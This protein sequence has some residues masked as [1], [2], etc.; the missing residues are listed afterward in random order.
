MKSTKRLT[1]FKLRYESL[2]KHYLYPSEAQQQHIVAIATSLLKVMGDRYHCPAD[3]FSCLLANVMHPN[4]F[5]V[6]CVTMASHALH[7][8][9]GVPSETFP[10]VN[11]LHLVKETEGGIFRGHRGR[12]LYHSSFLFCLVVMEIRL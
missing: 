3:S 5:L 12:Y 1:S 2:E 10:R 8:Q 7:A 4:K 11:G 9:H 6:L